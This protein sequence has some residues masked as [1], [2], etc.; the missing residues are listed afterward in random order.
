MNRASDGACFIVNADVCVRLV[1]ILTK[2]VMSLSFHKMSLSK[3]QTLRV[4]AV[5]ED[6]FNQLDILGHTLTR[7]LNGEVG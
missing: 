2:S 3:I 1:G 4:A 5:L 7:T 6:C